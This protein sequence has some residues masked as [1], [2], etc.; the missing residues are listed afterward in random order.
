MDSDSRLASL[1]GAVDPA[2]GLGANWTG[3]SND[4]RSEKSL[5][6]HA[7]GPFSLFGRKHRLLLGADWSKVRDDQ[8]TYYSEMDTPLSLTNVYEFDPGRIPFAV[9]ERMTRSY[10]GYGATQKASMVVPI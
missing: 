4:F 8:D 10:P 9:R 6:V 1:S 2:T 7:S 5:D 3:F